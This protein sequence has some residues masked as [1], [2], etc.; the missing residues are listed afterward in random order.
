MESAADA[1]ALLLGTSALPLEAAPGAEVATV[2]EAEEL[3]GMFGGA[4]LSAGEVLAL[5]GFAVG[6]A[7]DEAEPTEPGRTA[8]VTAGTPV[9]VWALAT[10]STDEPSAEHARQRVKGRPNEVF[11]RMGISTGRT[12]PANYATGPIF[13]SAAFECV[14]L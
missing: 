14:N 10:G 4:E 9:V 5:G 12:A 7:E 2:D 8:D 3:L 6:T 13:P 1:L 11:R